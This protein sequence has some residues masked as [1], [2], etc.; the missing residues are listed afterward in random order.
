[1][2][3]VRVVFKR[4][5][6]IYKPGVPYQLQAR[7]AEIHLRAGRCSKV[8][9]PPK[10]EPTVAIE[11]ASAPPDPPTAEGIDLAPF[12]E[13]DVIPG[14]AS[15]GADEDVAKVDAPPAATE[16]EATP[17]AVAETPAPKKTRKRK[18]KE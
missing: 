7:I 1:M 3:T 16:T 11:A 6:G 4:G 18:A 5:F 9:E 8:E 13:L 12:K 2:Q 15:S 10:P 17:P 14:T